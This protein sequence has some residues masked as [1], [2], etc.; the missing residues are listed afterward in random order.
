MY[1]AMPRSRQF[2]KMHTVDPNP[3]VPAAATLGGEPLETPHRPGFDVGPVRVDPPC[4]L[5]PME[6][7]T[8][9]G[10]RRS[11]R[12]LG[13]C[14]LTVTE[15]VSS[16]AMTRNVAKAWRMAEIDDDEHPVSIQ[17]Y[18]R[19]PVRMADAARFCEELGADIVDINLGCPSK[20]VTS[21]CSGSAL[22]REPELASEI[23]AAVGEAV[24]VPFTVK[25][26]MGWDDRSRNADDI[27]H[28]AE[29]AGAKM[30]V[31]HGR[32][33]MAMYK[34]E[35]D[36]P[37][38]ATVKAAVGVPVVVNGD[39]LTVEDAFRA[40]TLSGADGVMVGRGIMRN[41]WLL[42]Q[43]GEALRGQ[44]PTEPTLADRRDVLLTY[45]EERADGASILEAQIGRMKKVITY[46]TK[47]LPGGAKLRQALHRSQSREE[48]VYMLRVYF[49]ALEQ[50]GRR[51]AFS[52]VHAEVGAS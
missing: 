40:M 52:R 41:P 34:G 42:R 31:V 19:D 5:A 3:T 17:I 22:M 46:F 9:R 12:S 49:E 2:A 43:I 11:I 4:I 48:I 1:R 30:I 37:W 26:R 13:G 21:G 20:T 29:R 36:W 16:E 51:D 18:G 6:G 39:V 24:R 44:E 45:L 15:F 38:I 14:G 28:R 35:A 47:G 25:M 10:F 27:A 7:I 8:D 50:G 23:F 32:T 33:R